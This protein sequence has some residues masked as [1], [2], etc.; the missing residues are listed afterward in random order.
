LAISK[1]GKIF[2]RYSESP[3][4]ST[5]Q[6]EPYS[7]LTAPFVIKIRK[8]KWFMWYVS[9]KYWK[10]KN[11]PIYDIKYS[12]SKYGLNWVQK[13][14][15]CIKLN[16]GERAIA[17][18]YVIYEKNKF[19]MWYSYEKKVGSY[20]IG[21]AVSKNGLKWERH[22]NKIKFI[23]KKNKFKTDSKMKEYASIVQHKD[24]TYMFYN[25]NQ[26]GKFGIECA[27]LIK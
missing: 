23:D 18:P 2:K 15:T 6:N 25:G 20:K 22:D 27:Q 7:I 12:T 10:N 3:I 26:Y 8:S 11:F 19:K 21:Y 5:N 14:Q 13:K 4:L 24:E 17:R 1:K 9:C 16:K